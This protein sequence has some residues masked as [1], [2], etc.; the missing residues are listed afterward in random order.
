M[1]G[2]TCGIVGP[3]QMK[4]CVLE[5]PVAGRAANNRPDA[6]HALRNGHDLKVRQVFHWKPE[7]VKAH[8]AIAYM[9]FACVRQGERISP[10]RIRTAS[11][12][13]NA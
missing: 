9:A 10:E 2:Q 3:K 6:S 13:A 4:D 7:W 5:H 1:P 12:P 11:P 8:I